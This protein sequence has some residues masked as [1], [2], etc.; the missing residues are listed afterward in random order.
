MAGWFGRNS[1]IGFGAE[2]TYGTAVARTNWHCPISANV[3]RKMTRVPRPTLCAGAGGVQKYHALSRD[4]TG[5]PIELMMRYRGMGLPMEAAMGS[6]ADAGSG[7]YTHTFT[8]GDQQTLPSLTCE[9]IRGSSGDSETF[10]GMKINRFVIRVSSADPYMYLSLDTLC[11]TA[12]AVTTAG[13]PT[14]GDDV[15]V[16]FHQSGQFAWN[17]V[18]YDLISLEITVEN[19]LGSRVKLG[20][21]ASQEHE[22]T[23]RRVVTARVTLEV[24]DALYTAHLADT[25]NQDATI[26]FTGT[27]NDALAITLENAYVDAVDNPINSHGLIQ[28]TVTFKCEDDGTNLGLKL[29]FTNDDATYD[30]N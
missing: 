6:V 4:E 1:K 15:P 8:L 7:P 9:Q 26:T 19:N 12:A 17:S 3:T 10:E 14:D 21:A 11:E 16:L 2:V 29:V 13:S 22:P 5:G 18:N 25:N 30:V 27:G 28:Q 20:S 23:D 24:E